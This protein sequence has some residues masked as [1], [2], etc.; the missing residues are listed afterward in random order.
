MTAEENRPKVFIADVADTLR[1][2][3]K[4]LIKEIG[5]HAFILDAIPP[6][7]QKEPHDR[8]MTQVLEQVDFSIH[9]LDQWP[10]RELQDDDST[11]YPSH[12]T[13]LVVASDARALI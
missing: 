7:L 10:G 13:D 11:T 3:R 1:P 9:L 8:A 5:E 4:R 6:P 12:Q 2:F